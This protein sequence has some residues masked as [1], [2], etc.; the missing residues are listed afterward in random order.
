VYEVSLG[1]AR[2]MKDLGLV[3]YRREKPNPWQ[4][5][6]GDLMGRR[7]PPVQRLI[8]LKSQGVTP[9]FARAMKAAH[10]DLSPWD[11][12]EL[13]RHGSTQAAAAGR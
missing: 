5:L 11:L 8:E 12:I 1:Y 4:G 7:D 2:E 9:G 3:A 13:S 6:W 10:G